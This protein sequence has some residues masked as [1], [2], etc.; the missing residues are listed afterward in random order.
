MVHQEM[1]NSFLDSLRASG[2]VNMFGAGEY[3]EE[4]FGL[5]KREARKMLVTWMETFNDRVKRGE[6]LNEHSSD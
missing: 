1:V 5:N 4:A 2:A 3:I 6:V